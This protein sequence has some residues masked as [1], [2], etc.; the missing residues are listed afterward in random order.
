MTFA[1]RPLTSSGIEAPL[2]ERDDRGVEPRVSWSGFVV[3]LHPGTAQ[4][5]HDRESCR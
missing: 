1:S 3:P 5:F 4:K 2:Q